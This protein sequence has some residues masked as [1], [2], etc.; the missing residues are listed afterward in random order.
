MIL[1]NKIISYFE[2]C[3]FFLQSA[4]ESKGT[5][6]E[7]LNEI[8]NF[9]FSHL[10]KQPAPAPNLPKDLLHFLFQQSSESGFQ[11]YPAIFFVLL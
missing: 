3:Y 4:R 2:T 10:N 5:A 1:S 11:E 8:S 7:Q 9:I 6:N